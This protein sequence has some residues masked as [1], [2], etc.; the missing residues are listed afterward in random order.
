MNEIMECAEA[1]KEYCEYSECE[2]CCF[3]EM[4]RCCLYNLLTDWDLPKPKTFHDV[5][6]GKFPEA[7]LDCYG[8]PYIC[9]KRV[10]GDDSVGCDFVDGNVP[11]NLRTVCSHC[12]TKVAPKELQE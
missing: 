1:I 4:Q 12:W 6:L 2:T 8:A 3:Y 11:E 5:F 9:V 7:S 10:F